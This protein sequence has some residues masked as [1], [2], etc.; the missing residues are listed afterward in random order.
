MTANERAQALCKKLGMT[1][2]PEDCEYIA[3]QIEEAEREARISQSD[4][5]HDDAYAE[6][7]SASPEKA[8]KIASSPHCPTWVSEEIRSMEA[9][10]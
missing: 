1:R 10:E 7:F 3:A 6:G 4:A 2:Y 9:G 8:K 5:D